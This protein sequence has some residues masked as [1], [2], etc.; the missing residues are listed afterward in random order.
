MYRFHVNVILFLNVEFVEVYS[1]IIY[2]TSFILFNIIFSRD[3]F[4]NLPAATY[5]ERRKK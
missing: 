3:M 5:I 1:V 4:W 2:I